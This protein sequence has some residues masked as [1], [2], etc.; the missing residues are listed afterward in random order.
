MRLVRL[1]ANSPGS[2]IETLEADLWGARGGGRR[3]R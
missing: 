2:E 1:F 3:G